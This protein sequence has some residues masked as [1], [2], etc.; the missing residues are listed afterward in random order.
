MNEEPEFKQ[1]FHGTYLPKLEYEIYLPMDYYLLRE[2]NK[3]TH[4]EFLLSNAYRGWGGYWLVELIDGKFNN[5][6]HFEYYHHA[7][8]WRDAKHQSGGKAEIIF[9]KY[10]KEKRN[11]L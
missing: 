7:R 4:P 5:S 11:D 6:W 10:G 8:Y 1:E 9:P 2:R 3:E